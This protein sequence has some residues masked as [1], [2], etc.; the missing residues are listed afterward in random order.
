MGIFLYYVSEVFVVPLL[1]SFVFCTR[2]IDKGK[3]KNP[4]LFPFLIY[5][6]CI[7][8]SLYNS[9]NIP[10]SLVGFYHL[11]AMMIVVSLIFYTIE[12]YAGIKRI[13]KIFLILAGLNAFYTIGQALMTGRR[14]FGFAGVDSCGYSAMIIYGLFIALIMYTKSRV[15][16]GLLLCL[17]MFSLVMNRTR[18]PLVILGIAGVLF[19]LYF[20]FHKRNAPFRNKKIYRT[21]LVMFVVGILL[22]GT[23]T[24]LAPDAVQRL[25]SLSSTKKEVDFTHEAD[26]GSNSLLTRAL[27]WQTA[28]YAFTAHPVIGIGAYGFPFSSQLY[29]K[30]TPY[31]YNKIV[32]GV[33]THITYLSVI[34]ETGIIGLIGFIIFLFGISRLGWNSVKNA[35]TLEESFI[36]QVL[37]FVQIFVVL[38]MFIG[39]G[40]IFGQSSMYWGVLLGLTA[41]NN[42][43]IKMNR[44]K[45]KLLINNA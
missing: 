40:F 13:I 28:Y 2:N 32:K 25:T 19:L 42:K 9:I 22:L 26:F 8:P 43:I 44:E 31:V 6:A 18:G 33:S 41:A 1:I 20:M 24:V 36:S 14:V 3:L 17:F 7:I 10:M 23:A 30:L 29:H 5:I 45:E 12:D 21:V 35:V 37:Y 4:I 27:I 15:L 38:Q 39:D 11:F 34:T 16:N